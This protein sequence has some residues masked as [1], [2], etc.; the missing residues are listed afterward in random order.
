MHF[1]QEMH[2]W[3]QSWKYAISKK[4]GPQVFQIGSSWGLNN[5]YLMLLAPTMRNPPTSLQLSRNNNYTPNEVKIV[6][7]QCN[8]IW[9]LNGNKKIG[10]S[11][12]SSQYDY[13]LT[14]GWVYPP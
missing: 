3:I 14:I 10:I 2:A 7:S 5:P 12:S 9:T 1:I 6:K 8:G 11:M 4:E 13:M